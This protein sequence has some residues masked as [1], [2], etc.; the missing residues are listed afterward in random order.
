MLPSKLSTGQLFKRAVK[1]NLCV[2]APFTLQSKPLSS[3]LWYWK[4]WNYR[5]PFPIYSSCLN[6]LSASPSVK[7]RQLHNC[8]KWNAKHSC[9]WQWI[10]VYIDMTDFF[11]KVN[12]K[13]TFYGLNQMVDNAGTQLE[14]D[15]FGSKEGGILLNPWKKMY[16]RYQ[17]P[18]HLSIFYLKTANS[19]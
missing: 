4:V 17:L 13:S 19:L 1:C 7:G 14:H 8:V 9:G 11:L 18:F 10:Q 6:D 2:I 3:W 5:W 15:M 12:R 16:L